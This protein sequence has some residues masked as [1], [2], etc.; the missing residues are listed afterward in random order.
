MY[1]GV[2]K[3]ALPK[4]VVKRQRQRQSVWQ[5]VSNHRFVNDKVVSGKLCLAS[6]YISYTHP[7]LHHT[8]RRRSLRC[9]GTC[10]GPTKVKATKLKTLTHLVSCFLCIQTNRML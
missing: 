7:K 2:D 9:S 5:I 10:V 3:F 4:D 6:V 1:V 8:I